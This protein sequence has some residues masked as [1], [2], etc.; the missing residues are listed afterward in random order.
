RSR[1]AAA[2]REMVV[3]RRPL[4]TLPKRLGRAEDRIDGRD[5]RDCRR[6]PGCANVQLAR[7]RCCELVHT[8]GARLEL[9][10]TRLGIGGI[11]RED[12]CGHLVWEMQ[13]QKR[14]SC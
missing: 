6:S 4:T 3:R 11:D 13:G 7:D 2:A 14:K 10:G 1:C 12:V 8:D 9:S 5:L